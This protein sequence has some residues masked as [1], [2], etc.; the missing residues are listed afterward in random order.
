MSGPFV[1]FLQVSY[2][3]IGL[4]CQRSGVSEHVVSAQSFG[5]AR[6]RT[7]GVGS[8]QV[9]QQSPVPF[10]G[11]HQCAKCLDPFGLQKG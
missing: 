8:V 11:L 5:V 2:A 4:A 9:L 6:K 7:N 10:A 1:L 3:W